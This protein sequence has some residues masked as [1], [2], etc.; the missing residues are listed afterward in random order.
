MCVAAYAGAAIAGSDPWKTGWTS[1]KYAKL[2][3][4]V[5]ILMAFTPE[6]LFQSKQ[7]S[8]TLSEIEDDVPFANVMTVHVKAGDAVNEGDLI[9]TV[10]VGDQS[11]QVY[12]ESDGEE[13]G[14][15]RPRGAWSAPGTC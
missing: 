15:A 13:R 6:I 10:L 7:L 12:A 5:P 11:L 14:C 3:Y 2:L 8:M 9:A 1:F 4:V